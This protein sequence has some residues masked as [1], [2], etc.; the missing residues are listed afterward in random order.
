M[1]ST[2]SWRGRASVTAGFLAVALLM[3]GC[4]SESAPSASSSDSMVIGTTSSLSHLDPAAASDGGSS[5]V[6][7]QVFASLL[8]SQPG[9]SNLVP[10]LAAS[11]GFSGPTRF[12]VTLRSGLEFANGHRLTSSDVVFSFQRQAAIHAAGGAAPVLAGLAAVAA[13]GDRVVVFQLE[14]ADASFPRVLATAAAAIVDEQVFSSRSVTD[15]A[16]IVRGRAFDGQYTID[17]FHPG[18]LIT[19][20]RNPHYVGALGT[21]ATAD[22]SLKHYS[23]AFDL[24]LDLESGTLDVAEGIAAADVAA[25]REQAGYTVADGPGTEVQYLVFDLGAMPY[26]GDASKSQLV[27]QAVADLVDRSQLAAAPGADDD[28]PLY[29]F[30]PDGVDGAISV[31]K[32]NYGD[33]AGGPSVDKATAL[34]ENARLSIPISL[35]IEYNTNLFGA[36]S[37]AEYTE[38]KNQLERG[39]LFT[40]VL[41]KADFPQYETDRRAGVYPAYQFSTSLALPDAGRSL[42]QTFGSAGVA[43]AAA[44]DTSIN[45]R[46]RAQATELDA[47]K[48]TA[49]LADIQTS[50]AAGL[51][52]L[53]LLQTSQVV[54]MHSD[55]SGACLDASQQFRFGTL[56]K[57]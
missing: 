25:F 17:S 12:T 20:V 11:A 40:V 2:S 13:R 16:T 29:S 32:S 18:R 31:L 53:P 21:A 30:V 56:V 7:T 44:G 8:T 14:K 45:D 34:L 57:R 3:S 43:S 54:V 47:S 1:R 37:K 42:Q 10:D 4:A 35:K 23:N 33:G 24:R 26:A 19:F 52:I 39:G 46:I 51:P 36:S 38:L 6:Q 50:L 28:L 15:D 55:V 27:R 41:D 9:S 49:D 48:R 5:G 22:I